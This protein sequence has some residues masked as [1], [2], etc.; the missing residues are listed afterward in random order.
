MPSDDPHHLVGH[1]MRGMGLKSP[2]WA[3]IP[4]SRHEHTRLHDM[5]HHKWEEIYG[6]QRIYVMQTLGCAIDEGVLKFA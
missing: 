6:D 2:D 1:G 4:M 5:G 3:C